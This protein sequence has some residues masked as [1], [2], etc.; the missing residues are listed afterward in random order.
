MSTEPVSS[1]PVVAFLGLGAMGRPMANNLLKTGY[2]LVVWNR[3]AGRADDLV[4][5]GARSANSPRAAAEQAD[6]V[7][8]MLTDVSA[9]EGV[10]F[11]ADG[12][13]GGLRE[14]AIYVDMSTVTP[15][16]SRRL[17][18]VAAERGARF[19][20]A[21][22]TGTI[23]QAAEGT[24]TFIV[25]G[26][27]AVLDAVRPLL[28]IIGLDHHPRRFGRSG[29]MAQALGERAHGRLD[30]GVLRATRTRS[31]GRVRS[32]D[33]GANAGRNAVGV[34]GDAAQDSI[35]PVR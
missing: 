31:A 25:G 22:V 3:T 11:G 24:L 7:I 23:G 1:K 26:D 6:V 32:R 15:A 33:A 20:D 28:D 12:L 34:A 10:A 29:L 18:A 9:V 19:L 5:A 14:G 35:D 21:P 4:A 8:T 17:G 30:A 27:A 2:P 13:L 16:M